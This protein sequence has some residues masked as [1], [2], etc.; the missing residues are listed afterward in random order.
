MGKFSSFQK[1]IVNNIITIP[2]VKTFIA[3]KKILGF[4]KKFTLVQKK[5]HHCFIH[6]PYLLI[7]QFMTDELA[8]LN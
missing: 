6:L 2:E 8:C 1:G 4:R 7:P 3:S 5:I